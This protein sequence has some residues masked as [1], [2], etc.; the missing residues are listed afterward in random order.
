M[1]LTVFIVSDG[2][3]RTAEQ[4]LKAA[5]VQFEKTEVQ[6]HVRS[7]VRSK[8]RVS[9]IIKEAYQI[10]ALIIHTIV[11]KENRHFLLDQCRL[12]DLNSI[13]LMGPLLAQLSHNLDELPSEKPGIFNT[14]SKAYFQRIEAIEY[15]LN[16]DDGQRTDE[17]DK[18]DIVLL[19]VSR[20]FKTPLSV[21]LA[22]KG[23]YVANV[24][25]ILDFPLPKIIYSLPVDRVF[26]LRTNYSRLAELRKTR[27][28]YLKGQADYYSKPA[29]VRDELNYANRLFR[30][31][32][33]WKKINITN[34]PIEEISSEILSYLRMK[35][36]GKQSD[37][38][39][40]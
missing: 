24:P 5:R 36:I 20:T 17:L 13:D 32:P 16:H 15:M 39:E 22:Y 29:F 23:W 37:Q 19:G 9:E 14:I 38:T 34:K 26:C 35:K 12:F 25:I 8:E 33:N 4:A 27:S 28:H 18:A 10:K 11:S 2:T 21:Y 3:G 31:Q 30:T 6:T 7:E 40:S 1:K